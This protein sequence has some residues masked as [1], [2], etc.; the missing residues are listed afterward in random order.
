MSPDIANHPLVLTRG[1]MIRLACLAIPATVVAIAWL[2]AAETGRDTSI[3]P[4]PL[5]REAGLLL[6]SDRTSV[7]LTIWQFDRPPTA[8]P[9]RTSFHHHE[10]L[11]F[12]CSWGAENRWGGLTVFHGTLRTF[13]LALPNVLALPLLR[14]LPFAYLRRAKRDDRAA[15]AGRCAACGYDLRATPDRCPECGVTPAYA[16]KT[17]A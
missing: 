8:V 1:T 13:E 7:S 3:L 4:L 15:R 2:A 6:R 5:G 10:R 17:A 9:A 11:G 14:V 16:P 12:R